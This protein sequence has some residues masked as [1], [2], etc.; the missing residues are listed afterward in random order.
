M[1]KIIPEREQQ[2]PRPG[3]G[4]VLVDS[5]GDKKGRGGSSVGEERRGEEKGCGGQITA[6]VGE[7]GEGLRM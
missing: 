3:G 7:G 2:S 6:D 5:A 4:T 1:G